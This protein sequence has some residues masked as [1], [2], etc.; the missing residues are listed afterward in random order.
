MMSLFKKKRKIPAVPGH[1]LEHDA[2]IAEARLLLGTVQG[3]GRTRLTETGWIASVNLRNNEI[4]VVLNIPISKKDEK[5][6]LFEQCQS[7]L[8]GMKG[9]VKAHVIITAESQPEANTTAASRPARWNV[10]PLPHVKR[11]VAIA[12]GK[13]GVGKSTTAANLA[14]VA[15]QMGLR[16][17]LLDADIYGPSIP[18]LMGLLE[19]GQPEVVEETLMVPHYA[20]HPAVKSRDDM[21]PIACMSMGFLIS[22]K[23]AILRGPMVTKALTQMLRQT[24]WGSADAPLDVLFIDMPPGTGDIALSLAQQAPLNG[25]IIVTTPQELATADAEK[26]AYMFQK[27]EVPLYGVVENMSYFEDPSGAKHRLFGEGGGERMAWQLNCPLLA[28]VPIHEG[29]ASAQMSE[30]QIDTYQ[31]MIETILA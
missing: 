31:S 22:D 29:I 15:S 30:P 4:F 2:V 1:L 25:A 21:H 26:A 20:C 11:I 10:T 8:D 6:R 24:Q 23:A 5:D 17:G 16:A 28:S 27:V 3:E 13:G 9:A 18:R 19:K 7:V 12:S 14:R